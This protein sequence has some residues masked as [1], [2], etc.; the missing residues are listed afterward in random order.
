MIYR[1]AAWRLQPSG[2][3]VLAPASAHALRG[4][5]HISA[6]DVHICTI[7]HHILPKSEKLKSDNVFNTTYN[8]WVVLGGLD[9]I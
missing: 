6:A 9:M 2:W 5:P 3:Q 1:A 7:S 8:S 4:H